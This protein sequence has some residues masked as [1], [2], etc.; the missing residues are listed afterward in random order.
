MTF[1]LIIIN[2]Q[3]PIFRLDIRK[4]FNLMRTEKVGHMLD[5]YFWDFA[6]IYIVKV[7]VIFIVKN[8]FHLKTEPID[9]L[10]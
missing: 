5:L 3:I 6:V 9:F 7:L 1:K 2:I 10:L 4:N 8:F